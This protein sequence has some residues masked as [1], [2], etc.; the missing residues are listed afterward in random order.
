MTCK[1][2]ITH[3]NVGDL[4]RENDLSNPIQILILCSAWNMSNDV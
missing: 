3:Y 4:E 2:A 1:L